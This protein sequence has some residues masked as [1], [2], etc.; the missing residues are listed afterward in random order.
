MFNMLSL[1]SRNTSDLSSSKV[2]STYFIGNKI[3]LNP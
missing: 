3:K 1:Q 2:F